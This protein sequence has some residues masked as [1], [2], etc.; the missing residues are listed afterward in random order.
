MKFLAMALGSVIFLNTSIGLSQHVE[1]DVVPY[2]ESELVCESIDGYWRAEVDLKSRNIKVFDIKQN[3]LSHTSEELDF[4]VRN[5][6]IRAYEDAG[7][8]QPQELIFQADMNKQGENAFSIDANRKTPF[9][10]RYSL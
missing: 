7:I 1:S 6:V 5:R 3:V 2:L 9:S 10:C 8:G 4:I